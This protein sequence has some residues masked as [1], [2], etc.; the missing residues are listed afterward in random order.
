MFFPRLCLTLVSVARCCGMDKPRHP[1]PADTENARTTP[2]S[3]AERA[4]AALRENLRRRKAQTRARSEAATPPE[5]DGLAT[6]S[7]SR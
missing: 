7:S 2:L 5:Q 4:A 1:A 6:D 3:R